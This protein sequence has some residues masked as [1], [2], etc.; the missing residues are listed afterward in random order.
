MVQAD[1][2]FEPGLPAFGAQQA[3]SVCSRNVSDAPIVL[4]KS[5]FDGIGESS[6]RA[7]MTPDEGFPAHIA[8]IGADSGI[9]LASL[10]RF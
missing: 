2:R 6:G 8:G 4:K 3:F 1:R 7:V 9:S 5:V 10:R